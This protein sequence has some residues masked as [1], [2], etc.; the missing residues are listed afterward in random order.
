MMGTCIMKNPVGIGP[1]S[2]SALEAKIRC[3]AEAVNSALTSSKKEC[4]AGICFV[5]ASK[6][7]HYIPR[8]HSKRN[9]VNVSAEFGGR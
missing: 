9:M 4:L 6:L 7:T 8:L 3:L 5:C 1:M 2:C